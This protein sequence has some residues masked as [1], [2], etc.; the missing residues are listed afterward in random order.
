MEE[1]LRPLSTGDRP[2]LLLPLGKTVDM[3]NLEL[4]PG[5]PLPPCLLPFE[6]MAEEALLQI[7]AVVGVKFRPVLD[8]VHLQPFFLGGC[9]EKGLEISPGMKPL[10]SPIGR[11]K[12]RHGHL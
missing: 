11:G 1:I 5:L 4:N 7:H 10:P 2:F 6:I 9:P 3:A 12:K 8:P